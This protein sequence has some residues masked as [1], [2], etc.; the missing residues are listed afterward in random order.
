MFPEMFQMLLGLFF[1]VTMLVL[2]KFNRSATSRMRIGLTETAHWQNTKII[3]LRS[4]GPVGHGRSRVQ[5]Q[6]G[7]F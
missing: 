1:A 6:P 5:I 2:A 3:D 7:L 4:I